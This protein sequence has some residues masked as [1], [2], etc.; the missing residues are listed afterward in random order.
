MPDALEIVKAH[1][2]ELRRSAASV[3]FDD[4][5]R[6]ARYREL[7]DAFTEVIDE[8]KSARQRLLPI[9]SD[10][11]DLSDLPPELIEQLNLSKVDELEQQ[12]RDIIAAANGGEVGIDQLLIE[13]YRRHKVLQER[14]FLLNKLY[15]MG[16]KGLIESVEGKK[17]VYRIP[18]LGGNWTTEQDDDD[19]KGE[20]PF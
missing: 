13:L 6:A 16:N 17:G 9:S 1:A 7:A 12:V 3:E 8:L 2:A 15:R 5:R 20:I 14:R 10:L 19:L 4:E 11:G 18:K